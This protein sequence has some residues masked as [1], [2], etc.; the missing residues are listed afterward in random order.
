MSRELSEQLS[1]AGP[2]YRK[3]GDFV[4]QAR[5]ELRV[6]QNYSDASGMGDPATLPGLR[7]IEG[8]VTGLDNFALVPDRT[9]LTLHLQDGRRLD[10]QIIDLDG[11]IVADG[12]LYEAS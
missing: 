4:D 8:R 3:G 2:V 5:Y 10:F 12:D 9:R 11:G 6:Y 1:G 7:D